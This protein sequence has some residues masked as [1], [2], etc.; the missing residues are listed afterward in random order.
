[1]NVP[2]VGHVT[3]NSTSAAA[4]DVQNDHMTIVSTVDGKGVGPRFNSDAPP[5]YHDFSRYSSPSGLMQIMR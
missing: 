4:W 3:T 1:V 5:E 2:G